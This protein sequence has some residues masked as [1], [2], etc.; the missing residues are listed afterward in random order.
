MK[1]LPSDFLDLGLKDRNKI[2]IEHLAESFDSGNPDAWFYLLLNAINDHPHI[3]KLT[4]K[5][6]GTRLIKY[7]YGEVQLDPISQKK[8]TEEKLNQDIYSAMMKVGGKVVDARKIVAAQFALSAATVYRCYQQHI[9]DNPTC[10]R[11]DG[12]NKNKKPL[13]NFPIRG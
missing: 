1:K 9:E 2:I 5:K 12:R 13:K 3:P 4:K 10:P 8:R 7:Y 6:L 11:L